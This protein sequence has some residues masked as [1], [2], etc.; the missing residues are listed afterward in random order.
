MS[1]P[2]SVSSPSSSPSSSSSSS[3]FPSGLSPEDEESINQ[4]EVPDEDPVDFVRA[5]FFL[6]HFFRLNFSNVFSFRVERTLSLP[7]LNLIELKIKLFLLSLE[8]LISRSSLAKRSFFKA[9][10]RPSS[11]TYPRPQWSAFQ[12]RYM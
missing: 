7:S 12:R 8:L 10:A 9:S 2:R 1:L 3:S 4:I 11:P 5:L 6:S